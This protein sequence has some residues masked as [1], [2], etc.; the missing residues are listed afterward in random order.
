MPVCTSYLSQLLH[1]EPSKHITEV[2][3]KKMKNDVEHY[4][5]TLPELQK[6]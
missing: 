5:K 3:L 1:D 6:R 2:A 4:N